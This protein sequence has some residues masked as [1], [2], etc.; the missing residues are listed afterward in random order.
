MPDNKYIYY[1]SA[2]GNL[3]KPLAFVDM[4]LLNKNIEDVITRAQDKQIRIASKSIRSLQLLEKISRHSK[5][6][7]GIMS[8]SALE[9]EYLFQ[10]GF[11]N[12]LIAYPVIDKK[13][14]EKLIPFV[15]NNKFLTLMVDNPKHIEILQELGNENNIE[16][17]VCLDIDLS[18]QILGLHF[19]VY[20][21]PID[22]LEKAKNLIDVITQFSHINLIAVMGYE[23]QIAGLPDRSPANSFV[24][25][26]I[27]RSLKKRSIT[28][29]RQRRLEI[30]NYI[31]EMGIKLKFVNGGG[32][33]SVES[34]REEEKVSEV[35]VGSAFFAPRLFDYYDSFKHHPAAGYALEITRI[36]TKNIYTCHGGGYIASGSIGVDKEPIPFLPE[37]CAL[38]K[39]EGA[40]EV[41]TPVKY[42]G[43]MSL[44]IGDPIFF[45]HAKAGEFC[46]HFNEVYLFS[47]DSRLEA[48]KTYRGEGKK[49]L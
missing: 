46:E 22:T 2:L 36:P 38:L 5:Q 45:R 6:F 11:D 23:A 39:N 43:K 16:F 25:N 30:I 12:I 21:S 1:K 49:F 42:K 15:K 7:N 40:G 44:N 27:I 28:V 37:G 33:G 32:S 41:Q 14:L 48:V 20:R 29:L 24:V 10:N 19:G 31:E 18:L 17:N 34:T 47:K 9:A 26:R 4:D 8:Y 3:S 35:T 13:L